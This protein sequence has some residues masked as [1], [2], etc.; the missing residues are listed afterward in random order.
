M[1]NESYPTP[2][3]PVPLSPSDERNWA[4]LAHLSVLLNLVTGFGGPIA[5]IIIYLIYKDRSR[6]VAYQ[7]MQAFVF[8]LVWW[9]GGGFLA[10]VA[11]TITGVL[12]AVLI[13]IL[14]IPL[15]ILISAMPLA[16]LIYGIVGGIQVNGGQ[17]FK[18]WLVGDWVRGTLTG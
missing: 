4:M 13:G 16:A 2:V 6:Y 3:A 10:G 8:Q 11:W 17:D 14:C 5:A 18:Y 9:V 15:A 12:S 7:S 1:T